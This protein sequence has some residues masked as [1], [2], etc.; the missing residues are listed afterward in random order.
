MPDTSS[1]TTRPESFSTHAST[2]R[3][4]NAAGLNRRRFL[5]HLLA[6]TAAVSLPSILMA[7]G[8]SDGGAAGETVRLGYVSPQSGPL[9]AF[10]QPDP[11]VLSNVREAFGG[12]DL[13]FGD[14]PV[15]VEIVTADTQS[16]ASRAGEVAQR[17]INQDGVDMMLAAHTPDT[18][19]PVAA[20]CEAS[21]VPCLTT[22]APIAPWL[23]GGPY[24]Y[25]FHFFWDLPDIIDV[26][27]GM[28]ERTETNKVVGALWPNDPDGT[29]WAGAFTEALTSQGYTV[30]DP[31][32]Y[33]NGTQDF[34]A[35][36]QQWKR[37]G[38]EILTGV[39]IPPDWASV[40]RQCQQQGFRPKVAS[41]GKAIL[42]PAAVEALGENL[43]EGLSSEVWWSPWHP[44]TSSL[45]DTSAKAFAEGYDQQWTQPM[46]FTHALFEIAADVLQRAGSAEP[47]ALRDALAATNLETIVG[48]IQF[49]ENHTARTPLVGGQWTRGE[50]PYPWELEIVHNETSP[51]IPIHPADAAL[52]AVPATAQAGA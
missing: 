6:G 31:G 49:A 36:I 50:E 41:I 40:W 16:N 20:V 45:T 37:E 34:T 18:T 23:Q 24:D 25:S 29:A 43:A 9:A 4:G 2:P 7:C 22:V 51:S 39:P 13:Q 11:Y 12:A 48:P 10:A 42:F 26:F 27:T 5:Q 14:T 3:A 35:F 33:P 17:L 15:S 28:W 32:R 52:D 38:V 1:R 8:G 30:V 44:Y 47:A 21:Q 19:N 46:G